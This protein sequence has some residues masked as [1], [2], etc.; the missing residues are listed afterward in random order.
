MDENRKKVVKYKPKRRINVG[1]VIFAILFVYLV[2]Y[3]GLYLTRDK[4]SYYEVVKGSTAADANKTYEGI[5]IRAETVVNAESSGYVSHHIRDGAKTAVGNTV[6]SIDE[7][8]KLAALFA[9]N[10]NGESTL[11]QEDFSDIKNQISR[12]TQEYDNNSFSDVYDFKSEI[13]SLIAEKINYNNINNLANTEGEDVSKYFKVSNATVSGIVAYYTDGYEG[14]TFENLTAEDFTKNAYKKNVYKTNDLV[15]AGTPIYKVVTSEAWGIVIPLDKE[16][17]E[18][19]SERTQ[20]TVRLDDSKETYV[21]AFELINIQGK[22]YGK[23]TSNLNMIS[24]IEKRFVEVKLENSAKVGLKI[25]KTSLVEKDFYIIPKSY[26]TK[27]GNTKD[28][29][30]MLEVYDEKNNMSIEY[31]S[32]KIYSEDEE[33]Y[34][35]ANDAFNDGDYLIMANSEEKYRVGQKGTLKGVYNINNGYCV[36]REVIIIDENAEFYIV[37]SGTNYGL[38][39]YDHIVLDSSLVNEDD[40]VY[41]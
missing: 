33:Y 41:K 31:V 30:F 21:F 38:L 32:P 37:E 27:G 40:I 9:E 12:F 19:L 20:V 11:S 4:I 18:E 6:C 22:T 1:V 2:I 36:F 5:I 17:I 39:V 29:G 28:I 23:L 25:P 10:Q 24:F 15:E 7:S 34:Y 16:E 14:K 8:G 35:V 13:Q 3:A 26:G